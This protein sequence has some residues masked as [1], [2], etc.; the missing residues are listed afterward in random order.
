MFAFYGQTINKDQKKPTI[1]SIKKY[2]LDVVRVS[3]LAISYITVLSSN[4]KIS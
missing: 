1:I 2:E 3:L 4:M